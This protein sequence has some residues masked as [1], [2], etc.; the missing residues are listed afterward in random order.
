MSHVG[1]AHLLYN[2]WL[3]NGQGFVLRDMRQVEL[4]TC[5]YAYPQNSN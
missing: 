5:I 2:A 4:V 1:F 3:N